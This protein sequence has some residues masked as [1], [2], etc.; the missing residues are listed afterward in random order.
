[1][2]QPSTLRCAALLV[3]AVACGTAVA[4]TTRQQ[5]EQQQ[6]QALASA[7]GPPAQALASAKTLY[8][9][10]EDM[11]PPPRNLGVIEFSTG[12]LVDAY[13]QL[14]RNADAL[15]VHLHLLAL[16]EQYRGADNLDLCV[17]LNNLG[18]LYAKMGRQKEAEA[19]FERVL[20]IKEKRDP[21]HVAGAL[22]KLANH[23]RAEKNYAQAETAYLRL[24]DIYERAEG[25]D[26]PRQKPVLGFLAETYRGLGRN[27][28]AALVAA[29]AANIP[30]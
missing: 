21:H 3:L 17:N 16:Q 20:A 5:W 26:S 11:G 13:Q 28:Q 9:M 19:V 7:G 14:G 27:D 25:K 10:A 15:A 1:M 30:D 18:V 8:A 29:R 23:Y 24:L 2:K 22:T 12:L 4:A 6:A